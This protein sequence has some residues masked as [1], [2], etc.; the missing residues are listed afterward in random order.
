M[1]ARRRMFET[2]EVE[3]PG[4]GA[5]LYAVAVAGGVSD[6]LN[7]PSMALAL[8]PLIDGQ[9]RGTRYALGERPTIPP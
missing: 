3:F 5:Q 4:E 2:L 9:L 1:L 8:A 7:N 6:L